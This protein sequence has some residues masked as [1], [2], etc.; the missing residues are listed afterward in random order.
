MRN[1]FDSLADVGGIEKSVSINRLMIEVG[2]KREVN[3]AL[4]IFSNFFGQADA[5]LRRIDT[6]REKLD[7]FVW[8]KQAA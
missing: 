8:F 7:F 2:K 5:F 1:P 6:D 4:T 3:L